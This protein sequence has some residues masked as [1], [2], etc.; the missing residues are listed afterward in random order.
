M[1]K[2]LLKEI[3]HEESAI[4][5]LVLVIT[6]VI[7]LILA[8]ITISAITGDNGI[9]RNVGQAKEE[10]EIANEK[11]IVE[12]ATVQ[13]MGNNKYGNI[14]EDEL[15][16]ELD[17][18][19]GEGK[20]EATDIGE[21]FEVVFIDSNRYYTVDKDGNVGEA[22]D[23]IK[24]KNPGDITVG[25]DGETLDG[26]EEHPY[27]IWC[28]EDLVAFSNMVNG[29]GIKLEN[30][31]AVQIT[32]ANAFKEK[33][34]V[35]KTN[36]NFKSKL[37]YQDSERTDFGDINGNENDGNTLMNEMTTG[38]GFKPIGISN[39]FIGTFDG[40][41]EKT[42][43]NY[44]ISNLYINYENDTEL[45]SY[46]FGR[47]IG[48]F[49]KGSSQST[50]I[51]NLEIS[52]EIKGAGHTGGIIGQEAK[53]IENCINHANI[54]GYNMVGGIVGYTAQITNCTNT[55]DITITGRSWGYAGAGGIIGN[56]NSVE[57]CVNE[58]DI[59]GNVALGGIIGFNGSTS[60]KINNCG[61]YGN[62]TLN[63]GKSIETSVGGILGVN[64]QKVEIK[65]TYN[66]GIIVGRGIIS[67]TGGIVGASKGAY[68]E[69]EL[70]LSIYNSFNTGNVTYENNIAGGIVGNQ[71]RICA[72][73]YIYIE[74]CWSLG[75]GSDFGGMIGT[76]NNNSDTETKTEINHCYYASEKAIGQIDKENDE[77]IVNHAV[78]KTEKEIYTQQFVDLLN[79]Y[80]GGEEAYPTDW[81][82]WKLGEE[83]YPVFE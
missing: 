9:I 14:E 59:S 70:V 19:I 8:G 74:N 18:E 48:L 25:K 81:K 31:K 78:Q 39:A 76:I 12:K 65:N 71:G 73:N 22:Q 69:S 26:S 11:E 45:N 79:S 50:I 61:N 42:K 1:R 27:E 10:T 53:L 55:G 30:G 68:N 72:K 15:Q 80:T 3:N 64:A 28:I 23:I 83:G 66:Q 56:G 34:I 20:T 4:T 16:S 41:N 46:R 62:I 54:T 5:L 47:P 21:E 58:G 40:Q 57:N 13:A 32:T 24:D 52:G 17:K 7:L 51:K 36:L 38:T 82:T 49:A 29:N 67:G 35:L 37:S 33:Y 6:I 43:E 44:K 75:E 63:E 60:C 77:N 2:T